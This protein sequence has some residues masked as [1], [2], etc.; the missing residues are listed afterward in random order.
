MARVAQAGR[1]SEIL[2]AAR[3]EFAERGYHGARM[4]AIAQ[5]A[6]VADGTVYLY[7][8]NKQE[9][10]VAVFRSGVEA[11]M[12]GLE[13]SLAG[14]VAALDE[15]RA[16]IAFHLS[17]LGGRPE[18][19]RIAQVELRQSDEAIRR[20]VAEAVAPLFQRIDG[21]V[22]RGRLEGSLRTDVDARVVRRMIFGTLDEC[23]SAWVNAR[24]PYPLE[25][26]AGDVE[27]LLLGGVAR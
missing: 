5:A 13:Q 3:S 21:I 27:R 4:S 23:V 10:L 19:A 9:L 15:L 8:R 14:R 1:E 18:Q 17:Y 20:A 7:F 26:I 6:G 22:T 24:H 16:L 2:E 25:S 12:H 11:Y